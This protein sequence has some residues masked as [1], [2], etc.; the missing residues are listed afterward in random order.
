MHNFRTLKTI[1]DRLDYILS[2]KQKKRAVVVLLVMIISS[3]AELL[4]VSA[5]YPFLDTMMSPSV[6]SDKWYISILRFFDPQMDVMEMLITL[7]FVIIL[8]YLVKNAVVL[9]C[10][11][12]MT[13]FSAMFKRELSVLM[14]K[15]YLSRPYEFFVNTNTAEV[16][17]GINSDTTA[18]YETL[19]DVFQFCT[20]SLTVLLIGAYLVMTD[21]MVATGALLLAMICFL[22]IV[23]GF[24]R[25]M[26][27][28]GR[29]YIDAS[30]KQ[31][32][33]SI[34]AVNGT[35][36]IF[37]TDRRDCFIE[38]YER[39]AKSFEETMVVKN[40][41]SA[42]PDRL[43][44]GICVG[45]FVG[46]A[47]I[48]LIQG[49]DAQYFI[50]VL[51][52]FAMGA[53]KILPSI[54]RMSNR[55]NSIIYNQHG[56]ANCYENIKEARRIDEQ[57]MSDSQD[58]NETMIFSD[59]IVLDGITWKYRNSSENVINEL[60]LTINKGDSVAFIGVSGAGK[61]TL[62]DIILGLFKPQKGS[63]LMDGMDIFKIPHSWA[64]I[65][66]YVP[67]SVF[68]I[69][70]TIRANIAFGL[71]NKVIDDKKIWHAIEQ[72]QLADFVR[73]LPEGLNTVV[74]ERGVKFSGG[75][76]QRVA[77]ARALYDNP[78]VLVFDEATSALDSETETAV[79][80]SINALL[81]KKTIIIIAHRL[82]TIRNC[83]YIYE[84][85]DG[86]AVLRD[87][88]EIFA[89]APSNL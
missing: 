63:V 41:I 48:R 56:L 59:S 47:C 87:K 5:I 65:I 61:T 4:G 45:G 3:L 15:S 8:I 71:P 49:V 6:D 62:A 78:Q 10:T 86:S 11:Y 84:I 88:N 9:L 77:I 57:M 23:F 73:T 58:S 32:K 34:Q 25:K 60:S 31:Y 38:E 50:P 7:G 39:S 24:K 64:R 43:L 81:G 33:Y 51:G 55:I 36:E 19:S 12:I 52:A 44:E 89:V 66:G 28:I 75:Q 46:I 53:F 80:T 18:T 13:R 14:L 40:F 37:V 42:C 68:L 20:D 54:S 72:A 30:T 69:D 82:S 21:W 26:K 76:R 35:K 67:Q 29:E 74:G 16:Q 27:N 70:D 79:M 2:N 22:A 85:I 1:I 17:R 83:D